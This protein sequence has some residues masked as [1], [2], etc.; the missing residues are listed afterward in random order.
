MRGRDGGRPAASVLVW[1]LAGLTAVAVVE[2]AS[3]AG[4][5]SHPLTSSDLGRPFVLDQRGRRIAMRGGGLELP[6][7][8][9]AGVAPT[10]L[11]YRLGPRSH[12]P[13][14]TPIVTAVPRRGEPVVGPLRLDALAR[15]SLDA[16]LAKTGRVAL[17]TPRQ[18]FLVESWGGSVL[19]DVAGASKTWRAE[20]EGAKGAGRGGSVGKTDENW[21]DTSANAIK[22]WN[23]QALNAIKGMFKVSSPKPVIIPPKAVAA[24]TLSPPAEAAQ[25]LPA[26]VPEPGSL[27]VFAVGATIAAWRFRPGRRTRRADPS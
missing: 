9:P 10:Y 13:D 15:A 19:S 24:Q 2:N 23:Q 4:I 11:A 18:S 20:V 7:R 5:Q 25:V 17:M 12:A 26:P 8:L 21:F 22:T 16:E 6:P 27:I 1:M 14:G 3:G